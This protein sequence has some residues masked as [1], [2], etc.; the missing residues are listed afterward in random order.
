MKRGESPPG[1]DDKRTPFERFRD[2]AERVMRIPK[3]D[4]V[5]PLPR[6]RKKKRAS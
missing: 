2:L 6:K 3:D 5:I 1:F 4:V